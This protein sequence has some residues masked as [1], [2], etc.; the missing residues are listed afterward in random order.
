MNNMRICVIKK[1]MDGWASLSTF[2]F[3]SL[4]LTMSSTL[5]LVMGIQ[6][7]V[8]GRGLKWME[9]FQEINIK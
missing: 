1:A 6:S 8:Q 9:V 7:W 5:F 3:L 4:S 2:E